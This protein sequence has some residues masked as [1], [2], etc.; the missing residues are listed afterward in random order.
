MDSESLYREA[1]DILR[2]LV[3]PLS[4]VFSFVGEKLRVFFFGRKAKQVGNTAWL[5]FWKD[6]VFRSIKVQLLFVG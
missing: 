5:I 6:K 2:R 3:G 4:F 1:C